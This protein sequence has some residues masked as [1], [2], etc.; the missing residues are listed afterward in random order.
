MM[1]QQPLKLCEICSAVLKFVFLYKFSSTDMCQSQDGHCSVH[2]Q[3]CFQKHRSIDMNGFR[4]IEIWEKFC[5]IFRISFGGMF[6]RCCFSEI[7][8]L[9]DTL[10]VHA[11]QSLKAKKKKKIEGKKLFPHIK[12][13]KPFQMNS[14]STYKSETLPNEQYNHTL[15]VTYNV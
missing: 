11:W 5:F 15:T 2:P 8:R 12:N 10:P 9:H 4:L 1:S 7:L 14:V 6:Y 13:Q 3:K